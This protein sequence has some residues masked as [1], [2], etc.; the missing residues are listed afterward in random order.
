[1]YTTYVPP[2]EHKRGDFL[3]SE[4]ETAVHNKNLL[5]NFL[6]RLV[7][8]FEDQLRI[9]LAIPLLVWIRYTRVLWTRGKGIWVVRV[10]LPCIKFEKTTGVVPVS[11]YISYCDSQNQCILMCVQRM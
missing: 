1:M 5:D 3:M 10:S 2:A 9:Y 8:P 4:Y 11:Y 7:L 6:F